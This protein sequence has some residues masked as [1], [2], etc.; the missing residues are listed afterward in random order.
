[1]DTLISWLTDEIAAGEV[2]VT[3]SQ[4][5]GENPLAREVARRHVATLQE[6][7]NKTRLLQ[8]AARFS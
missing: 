3:A 5:N 4:R 8:H 6:V 1:M 2:H 7:L